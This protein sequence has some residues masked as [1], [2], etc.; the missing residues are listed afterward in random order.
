MQTQSEQLLAGSLNLLPPADQIPDQDAI[1]LQ[2]WRADQAGALRSRKGS[3]AVLFSVAET[4]RAIFKAAGA[5]VRRYYAAGSMMYRNS[6][7]I[8]AGLELHPP[9]IASMNGWAW[10]MNRGRQ[11]KDDGTHTYA[12]TPA[13]P[14]A[15]PTDSTASGGLLNGDVSYWVT[16]DTDAEHESNPSPEL[17]L[18]ALVN[19]KVTITRPSAVPD[20]QVTTWN[21]Y[22]MDDVLPEPYK[23]N[24]APIPLATTTFLDDGATGTLSA[25]DLAGRGEVLSFDHDPAP[26][27]RGCCQFQSK[28]LAW[29]T[30][31]HPNRL[32]WSMT[33]KPWC[34][35]GSA[36]E[37]EGNWTPVGEEDEELVT[38]ADFPKLA[39]LLK[40]RSIYRMVGDPD[41]SWSEIDRIAPDIGLV[42]EKAWC[43]AG[44]RVY[45]QGGE[46]IYRVD[47]ETC[48]KV[49]PQL[50]PIFKG[51][52]LWLGALPA[53]P[54]NPDP[55]IRA[56]S[57]MEYINGRVYYSYADSSAT[58]PN[59]TLV[60]DEAGNRW[61]SDSRAFDALYYEGQGGLLLGAIRGSVFPLESGLTDN[62]LAIDLVYQSRYYNQQA[63]NNDK[64]YV[65]LTIEHNTGGRV[66]TVLAYLDNG[67]R[68]VNLGTI[69]S[70]VRTSTPFRFN[71]GDGET[72]RNVSIRLISSGTGSIDAEIFGIGL[73]YYVNPPDG[74]TWDS[75]KVTLDPLK[76]QQVD[77]VAFDVEATAGAELDWK[78][79]TDL[80]GD[81]LQV[82]DSGSTGEDGT[83]T[84][85]RFTMPLLA[86]REARWL[87]AVLTSAKP[88]QIRGAYI[89]ARTIGVYLAGTQDVYRSDQLTLGTAMLKLWREMRVYCDTDGTLT[90]TFLTDLPAERMDAR[91]SGPLDTTVTTPGARWMRLRFDGSTRG[92]AGEV[93]LRA[94]APARIYALQVRAKVLGAGLTGWQWVD[95]PLAE[96]SPAF[97]W[98]ALGGGSQ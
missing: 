93:Q 68:V 96:T 66:L 11:I 31:E 95:V 18:T 54:I 98:V 43:H 86:V 26:M 56:L 39:I 19:Q 15:A 45:L 42:G 23:V 41:E 28:M 1:A 60:F 82:R 73:Q 70:L 75:G 52:A 14:D 47:G 69:S 10:I 17:A 9:S 36:D 30:A 57:S 62:G 32:Y 83:A 24:S 51:D 53:L 12:W 87:R 79:S 84:I 78:V 71:E 7:A 72:A 50:D 2:N 92:R 38:V 27:A 6:S 20:A 22:R 64:T 81:E 76:V 48:V 90:G 77:C 74:L 85:R 59:T 80:P 40:E 8:A 89:H 13:A 61:Y 63:P 5:T 33:E 29:S 91:A 67:S 4:V 34:F 94:S 21:L 35:P 55:V 37:E 3:A 65:D 49:S 58:L 16:W 97:Q 25:A 88:F 46:G 44:G